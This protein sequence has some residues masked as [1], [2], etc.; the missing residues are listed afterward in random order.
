MANYSLMRVEGRLLILLL[1]LLLAAAC[2]QA[3]E[4]KVSISGS[5]NVMPL[6]E[7]A[8]EEFNMLQDDYRVTVTSGG[9]GVG[10]VDAAEGRSDIAMAS[11]EIQ[12]A[13]RQRYETPTKRFKVIPVGFD[14]ICLVVSPE[15][16]DSG[17][18]MLTRDEVKQIYAGDITN[19]DELG[20]PDMEIFVIGRK[21]G[22]GT[23]DTFLEAIFGSK[24]SETPGV[25]IES[26][27]SSEVKTA[28]QGSDNAIGYMGYSYVMRGD[29]RVISL[30]GIAP[31]VENIKNGTYP[32]ARKL[33][34][35]TLG[36]PTVGARAYIDYVLSQ[37]GQ[38]IAAENGFI[39]I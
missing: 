20:G 25:I 36:E 37:D 11:R 5:T 18:T 6:A 38:Q 4:S 30:D 27:D 19:W 22:S 15:V 24:E 17:V 13:E 29:T 3:R 33:Y 10:I 2:G 1:V 16:Y 14:A 28:I 32:I 34:F 12:L 23:R 31:T 26:A 21:P 9:T 35:V 8:A 39:P 7:L